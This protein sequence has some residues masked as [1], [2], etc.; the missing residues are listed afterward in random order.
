MKQKSYD[1]IQNKK[2]TTSLKSRLFRGYQKL[3]DKLQENTNNKSPYVTIKTSINDQKYPLINQQKSINS[4][5]SF[6]DSGVNVK[7]INELNNNN[8]HQENYKNKNVELGKFLYSTNIFYK[9]KSAP[10]I[11]NKRF[12]LNNHNK[13]TKTTFDKYLF[14]NPKIGNDHEK[15]LNELFPERE[16]VNKYSYL[17]FVSLVRSRNPYNKMQFGVANNFNQEFSV[18]DDFLFKISHTKKENKKI[19]NNFN[20]NKGIKRGAVFNFSHQKNYQT[21]NRYEKNINNKKN[22][23]LELDIDNLSKGGE[24]TSQLSNAEKRIQALENNLKEIKSIP[25]ELFKNLEN[26]VF[27]FIDDDFNESKNL[28]SE[29]AENE[30]DNEKNDKNNMSKISSKQAENIISLSDQVK[31]NNTFITDNKNYIKYYEDIFRNTTKPLQKYPIN[32]YSTQQLKKKEHFSNNHKNTFEERLKKLNENNGNKKN[33]SK[34]SNNK[35][36]FF[37]T[38]QEQRN[39]L[40]IN[41]DSEIQRKKIITNA[42]AFKKESKIRDVVLGRQLKCE[43]SPVDIKRILNGL[44]PWVDCNLDKEEKVINKDDN[45]F[46]DNNIIKEEIKNDFNKKGATL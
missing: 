29:K 34:I 46:K 14:I 1:I 19:E 38:F 37:S 41:Y 28:K 39:N 21:Q 24:K 9:N 25:N 45:V 36:K 11:H 4:S 33:N 27:R 30:N 23:R 35:S 2:F 42:L 16:E 32:F 26:D 7:F 40:S 5:T 12:K 22:I 17:P 18:Q 43:F 8:I 31:F 10:K 44:K 6:K 15:I 3:Q 13:N 20:R